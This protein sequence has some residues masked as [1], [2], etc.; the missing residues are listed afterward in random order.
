[1]G[2]HWQMMDDRGR[3]ITFEG[4]DGAGKTTQI[5]RVQG[6]LLNHPAWRSRRSLVVTREPGGTAIGRQLRQL[7]LAGPSL[8]E[9]EGERLDE[10]AELMLY[11]A[12][13]A[14]HVATVLV[15]TLMQ[16]GVVLCD[17]YVD[18]TIA[19]QGYGRQLNLKMIE[20]LNN[21]ATSG[22]R[23]DLT[24]WLDV[25][26]DA[27]A[28]RRQRRSPGEVGD[29]LEEEGRAFHERVRS[30]FAAL[31]QRDCDRVVRIDGTG[32]EATVFAQVQ[33]V[34]R[35]RFRSWYGVELD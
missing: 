31:A 32:D 10:G 12:D 9:G 8:A 16:G 5:Q 34:L 1:M 20:V 3:F 14:Q 28:L 7:L 27:G 23:P 22:L 13:R 33:G 6:W 29:R 15:P 30:G 4:I 2:W 18:S 17:R 11:A 19:Y 21:L 26:V 24:L 35:D 25:P